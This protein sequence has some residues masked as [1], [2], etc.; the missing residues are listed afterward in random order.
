MIGTGSG[1]SS[2]H[3]L[4][5]FGEAHTVVMDAPRDR[6]RPDRPDRDERPVLP[7]ITEDER[8]LGW[9]DERNERDEEWYRRER[10]PHHE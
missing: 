6:R 7:E 8:A 1:T 3:C 10:P 2:K 9:G 4:R 5:R